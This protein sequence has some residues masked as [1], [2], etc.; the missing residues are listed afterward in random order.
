VEATNRSTRGLPASSDYARRS[1]VGEVIETPIEAD[2][3]Q[4]RRVRSWRAPLIRRLKARRGDRAGLQPD[5]RGQGSEPVD[6]YLAVD[7][8]DWYA[9]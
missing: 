2:Y 7:S 5:G 9:R 8:L 1:T 6:A 4:T 3:A